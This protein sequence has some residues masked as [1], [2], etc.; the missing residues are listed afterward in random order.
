MR[1][2]KY[3]RFMRAIN[4]FDSDDCESCP[5]K[6]QCHA[7]T[8]TIGSC[9]QILFYYVEHGGFPPKDFFKNVPRTY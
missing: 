6:E 8:E 7:L 2:N 1:D 4:A 3:F 9:E 5:V